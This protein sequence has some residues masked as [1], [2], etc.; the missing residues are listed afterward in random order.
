MSKFQRNDYLKLSINNFVANVTAEKAPYARQSVAG[1]YHLF[2][3]KRAS[4]HQGYVE[5]EKSLGFKFHATNGAASL[6]VMPNMK[7]QR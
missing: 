4:F 6:D 7:Q 5:R 2:D 1:K 3:L